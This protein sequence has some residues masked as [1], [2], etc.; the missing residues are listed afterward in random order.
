MIV[1]LDLS[2]SLRLRDRP[3]LPHIQFY[4]A[5]ALH[6][7]QVDDVLVH[8]LEAPQ[9]QLQLEVLPMD[10]LHVLSLQNPL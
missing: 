1:I 6:L 3:R 2:L 10:A 8:S 4:I 5:N 9:R 7:P